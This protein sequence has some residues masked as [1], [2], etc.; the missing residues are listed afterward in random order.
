MSKIHWIPVDPT[1]PIRV[2]EST[3]MPSRDDMMEFVGGWLEYVNVL[4]EGHFP[5][6]MIVNEEGRLRGLEPNN[7]ATEIYWAASKAR[8][9]DL[10]DAAQRRA[11]W[12]A[13]A[14][15]LG[16]DPDAVVSLDPQPDLP[17]YIHGPAIV[18]QGIVVS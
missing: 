8:G 11:D 6:S 9:V 1:E 12:D 15:S 14:R 13:Y 17:P 18:L 10:G 5:T 2:E 7:R 16:V 4:Y 3:T